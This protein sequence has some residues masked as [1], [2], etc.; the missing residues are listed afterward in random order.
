M[1]DFPELAV[2]NLS[3]IS[4]AVFFAGWITPMAN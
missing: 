1:P 3:G 4:A 2:V